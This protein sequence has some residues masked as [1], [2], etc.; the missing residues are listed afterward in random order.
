MYCV[1]TC[2]CILCGGYF[3]LPALTLVVVVVAVNCTKLEDKCL[4]K[5]LKHLYFENTYVC[6]CACSHTR[7]HT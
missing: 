1:R 2:M 5:H 6:T 3:W 4:L 7:T